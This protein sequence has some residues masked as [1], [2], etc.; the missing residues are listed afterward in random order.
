MMASASLA[1]SLFITSLINVTLALSK[2]RWMARQVL[3]GFQPDRYYPVFTWIPRH[4]YS[5]QVR[6]PHTGKIILTDFICSLGNI[7]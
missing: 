4:Y 1:L 3:V 6:A 5:Y 2:D 7:S